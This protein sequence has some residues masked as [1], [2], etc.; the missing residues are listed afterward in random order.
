[1][2]PKYWSKGSPRPH[3]LADISRNREIKLYKNLYSSLIR[4]L[5]E[6][7]S[8]DIYSDHISFIPEKMRKSKC[9]KR[10]EKIRKTFQKKIHER[11]S[12]KWNISQ[13]SFCKK[14]SVRV[15]KFILFDWHV[16]RLFQRFFLFASY[17]F[18]VFLIRS[19]WFTKANDKVFVCDI[20]RR[21]RRH[22]KLSCLVHL[23]V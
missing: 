21:H 14:Y 22:N 23:A 11:K 13:F 8:N 3:T 19:D 20:Q 2:L 17:S 4:K 1:M 7:N 16:I 15:F 10:K 12:I 5:Y 18:N 6:E 9:R